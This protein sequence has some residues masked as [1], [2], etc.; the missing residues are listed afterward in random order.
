MGQGWTHPPTKQVLESGSHMAHQKE[1]YYATFTLVNKRTSLIIC[2]GACGWF[3]METKLAAVSR[4]KHKIRTQ[5]RKKAI[6]VS[7]EFLSLSL[8]YHHHHVPE[9]PI[10]S[11]FLPCLCQADRSPRYL[12]LDLP[13]GFFAMIFASF[14]QAFKFILLWPW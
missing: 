2:H 13:F 11:V 14:H 9:S 7:I 6:R 5:E 10:M 3:I 4:Y 8:I 12:F 1:Q